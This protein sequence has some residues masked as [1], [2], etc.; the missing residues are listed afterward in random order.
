MIATRP[1]L[2]VSR[3]EDDV[4]EGNQALRVEYDGFGTGFIAQ[5][6]MLLEPGRYV[7]SGDERLDTKVPETRLKWRIA[8]V[9][10]PLIPVTY[11]PP[12]EGRPEG[13]WRRFRVEF[14]VPATGCDTQGLSL[15]GEPGDRRRTTIAWF[16]NLAIGKSSTRSV[17]ADAAPNR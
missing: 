6:L 12:A 9:G 1:G 15:A 17:S 2:S 16:D 7:L 3:I 5:Q 10:S 11:R 4:S 8:C 14:E 13:Q